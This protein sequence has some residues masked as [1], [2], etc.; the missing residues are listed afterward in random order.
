MITIVC[1]GGSDPVDGSC[2]NA[3]GGG[4]AFTQRIIQMGVTLVG[5]GLVR[6]VIARRRREEVAAPGVS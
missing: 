3:A 5:L 1:S 4:T 2:D 6:T